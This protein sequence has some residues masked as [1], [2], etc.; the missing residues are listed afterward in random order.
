MRGRSLLLC[1]SSGQCPSLSVP[2]S[3]CRET[4]ETTPGRSRCIHASCKN[5]SGAYRRSGYFFTN[6]HLFVLHA[7]ILRYIVL[8]VCD[9]QVCDTQL[10]ENEDKVG[11][12]ELTPVV[13]AL[14]NCAVVKPCQSSHHLCGL[15]PFSS[16]S[17]DI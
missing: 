9:T 11:K 4:S 15:T 2:I 14:T 8:Q 13:K 3:G 17:S 16:K 5:V 10:V 12:S 7:N 6:Y 1:T